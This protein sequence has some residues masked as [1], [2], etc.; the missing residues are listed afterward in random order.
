MEDWSTVYMYDIKV[1]M[2]KIDS[3]FSIKMLFSVTADSQFGG[4][5][6]ECLSILRKMYPNPTSKQAAHVKGRRPA[7]YWIVWIRT[8]A[9]AR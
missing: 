5:I 2:G 3:S 1:G 7:S 9:V 8:L 6:D 4:K